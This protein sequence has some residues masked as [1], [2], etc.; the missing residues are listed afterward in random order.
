M[1]F[2]LISNTHSMF[3]LIILWLTQT[4]KDLDGFDSSQNP[5]KTAEN[6][7]LGGLAGFSIIEKYFLG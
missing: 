3:S 5:G 4:S 1:L 2:I 7:V 6:R